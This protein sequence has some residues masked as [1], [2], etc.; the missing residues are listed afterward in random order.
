[1][2]IIAGHFHPLGFHM[3]VGAMQETE[4]KIFLAATRF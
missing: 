2:K 4:A 1:M 3:E